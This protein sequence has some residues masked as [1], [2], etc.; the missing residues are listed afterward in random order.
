MPP[1]TDPRALLERAVA[2]HR[3]GDL[4][5]AAT[6]YRN[7][8]AHAPRDADAQHLLGVLLHQQGDSAGALT[9][10]EQ[11]RAARP[12]NPEI[13]YNLGRV[14]LA[15]NDW[16]MT[17]EANR[18][19]LALKP[20]MGAAACNLGIALVHEGRAAEGAAAIRDGIAH[21][22]DNAAGWSA[23]GLALHHQAQDDEALGAWET[24][25]ARDPLH[26]EARFNLATAYLRRQ[27]FTRGWS[28][29]A[30]RAESDRASFESGGAIPAN[31]PRWR[32]EPL[33]D[34]SVLVWAEQGLGDQI[35]FASLLPDLKVGALTFAC[36]PRLV[37]LFAR[38]LP[39]ATVLPQDGT[40]ETVLARTR[41]DVVVPL[42]DLGG[43][44]RPQIQDF[45]GARAF[46]QADPVRI[47]Q[48]RARYR[49][50]AAGRPLVGLSWHSHRASF[51]GVKSIPLPAWARV[52]AD[53]PAA[54]VSLQYGETDGDVAAAAQAGLAV[55]RDPAVDATHDLDG[56]AAQIG[57][58]DLV[59]T[60]SNTTAH[61]AGGLGVPTWT[62]VPRGGGS[63]WYWFQ[64][65]ATRQ[66]NP[67]YPSLRVHHQS[68]PGDWAD[69]LQRVKVDLREFCAERFDA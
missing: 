56:L 20:D 37:P 55:H 17:V 36:A 40:L 42:G 52:L 69:L 21:G 33:A 11:A 48:L 38:A 67:W 58:M 45:S 65:A 54:F 50:W 16:P 68:R 2:Q 22:A 9:L 1:S 44:L 62:L 10:I 6:L 12:R 49:G 3:A 23:L 66:Q 61:L 53:L 59:L 43:L 5:G 46:L 60:V 4:D 24:A 41:P 19:A 7:V 63:L 34:K 8:L 39:A 18:A 32:G 27:D 26:A 47:A 30:A 29:F 64:P 15:L 25:L 57:A 14:C 35:L 28:L 51:G 31:I 13:A